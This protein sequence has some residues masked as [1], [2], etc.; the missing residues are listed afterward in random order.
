M[1]RDPDK[2]ILSPVSPPSPCLLVGRSIA[3][4]LL[5]QSKQGPFM[6]HDGVGDVLLTVGKGDESGFEL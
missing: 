1:P 2:A 6:G 5:Y 3:N 4:F